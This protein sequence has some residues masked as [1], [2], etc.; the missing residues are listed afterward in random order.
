MKLLKAWGPVIIWMG[1]IFYLSHQPAEQSSELS[2]GITLLVSNII[3]N[4]LPIFKIDY[5]ALTFIVRKLAHLMAYLVLGYLLVRALSQK[6][7]LS[8]TI[9]GQAFFISVMFAISDE[10]HQ[11]FIPGRSGEVRD[12]IIDSI[13]AI[14]GIVIFYLLHRREEEY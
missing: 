10:I 1:V 3:H 2:N 11:L 14:F 5:T 7:K 12:V 13:G 8:F 9:I 4:I 6:V